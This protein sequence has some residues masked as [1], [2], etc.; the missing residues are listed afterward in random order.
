ML[1]WVRSRRTKPIPRPGTSTNWAAPSLPC[2]STFKTASRS[3]SNFT[4]P[5][6]AASKLRLHLRCLLSRRDC[7]PGH[8]CLLSRRDCEPGHSCTHLKCDIGM[9]QVVTAMIKAS[10]VGLQKRRLLLRPDY[11]NA[12][13]LKRAI[14]NL[15]EQAEKSSERGRS[16][17]SFRGN[18]KSVKAAGGRATSEQALQPAGAKSGQDEM[19]QLSARW[20][21]AAGP[22]CDW[23]V[24]S[25]LPPPPG[26]GEKEVIAMS[27]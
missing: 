22:Q 3:R 1:R 20:P 27:R 4:L 7:E 6:I 13:A 19:L 8:S 24:R 23:N 18:A 21:A 26:F 25:H 17:G 15:G 5:R 12:S 2:S 10:K 11:Q 16:G 14:S 9:C